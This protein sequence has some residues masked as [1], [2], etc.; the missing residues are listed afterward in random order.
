VQLYVLLFNSFAVLSPLTSGLY[1]HMSIFMWSGVPVSNLVVSALVAYPL[2]VFA[3]MLFDTIGCLI[4]KSTLSVHPGRI[5][6]N[7]LGGFFVV[8]LW[9]SILAGLTG[10]RQPPKL[11]FLG[12][13]LA[14][15][16]N[17]HKRDQVRATL[18]K[19][20]QIA[21]GVAILKLG[22]KMQTVRLRNTVPAAA[23]GGLAGAVSV[24]YGVGP[25]FPWFANI[26]RSNT[27]RWLL[28]VLGLIL[29]I[30]F[31]VIRFNLNSVRA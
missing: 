8:L 16:A 31:C 11:A 4:W 30:R 2:A 9:W 5:V 21:G 3:T 27:A 7:A 6:S 23:V 1:N 26:V 19:N 15:L 13:V 25:T 20:G 10:T 28:L 14:L 24:F 17:M 29:V 22:P 12:I 18:M